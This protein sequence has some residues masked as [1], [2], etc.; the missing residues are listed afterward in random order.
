LIKAAQYFKLAA[1]Q[2]NAEAQF[3]YGRCLDMG[4]GVSRDLMEAAKYFKLAAD[5][6]HAAGQFNY[7]L[8]RSRGEGVSRDLVQ[9]ASYFKLAADQKHTEAQR[10]YGLSLYESEGVSRDLASAAQYLKLAADQNDAWAQFDYGV[11]LSKGEGVPR[12]LTRAVTYFKLAADQH[13]TPAQAAYGF[14]LDSGIGT[15]LRPHLA[16][17]FYQA[18][19]ARQHSVA[20]YRLGMHFEFGKDIEKDVS[21]AAHCYQTAALGDDPADFGFCLEHG[22]GIAQDIFESMKCY[23]ES[24]DRGSP[25]GRFHLSL[26]L[27][28]GVGCDADLEEAALFCAEPTPDIEFMYSIDSFRCLRCLNKAPWPGLLPRKFSRKRDDALADSIRCSESIRRCPLASTLSDL[29]TSPLGNI[30]SSPI[31][32]GG[33]SRVTVETDSNTG[34]R[35]AVKHILVPSAISLLIREAQALAKLCHP[36]VLRILGWTVPIRSNTAQIHTE[37]ASNGSLDRLLRNT[38]RPSF[39]NPTGIGIIICG[40]VLG[41]RYIHFCR[42]IHRDLKPANIMLNEYGRPLIGDLGSCDFQL[43]DATPIPGSGTVYYAAPEQYEEGATPTP[44]IDVFAFGLI[45]YELL[46]GSPVFSRSE[47]QFNVIRRLRRRDFPV[48]PGVC[49]PIMQNLIPR[50]WLQDPADRPSFRQI[51]L[52]FRGCDFNILPNA[53]AHELQSFCDAV[54]DWERNAAIEQ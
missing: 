22:L 2:N 32:R 52:E 37:Y 3:R 36:C 9:A 1:H 28:Y 6:N 18:A 46:V 20:S 12:D 35:V 29:V 15:A 54:L 34:K 47:S 27:H 26:S 43:D 21:R 41:M 50:C 48:V 14:C 13:F 33:S 4:E 16:C 11:C 45:L 23:R 49:G 42:V 19:S 24:A 40:I 39:Q 17:A 5:Q 10:R 31:G 7:G 8:C 51:F 38:A 25:L 53:A 44:K 30:G